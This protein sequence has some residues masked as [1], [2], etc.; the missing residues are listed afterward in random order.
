MIP[1]YTLLITIFL[2]SIITISHSDRAEGRIG[3]VNRVPEVRYES[4]EDEAEVDLKNKEALTFTWRPTPI[5]AGG[6]EG[7]RFKVFKGTGYDEIADETL[8]PRTFSIK[9]PAGKFKNEQT[10]SWQVQQ[11]SRWQPK[12]S[13]DVFWTFKV[14]K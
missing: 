4:P 7:Y 14:R 1:K 11:R 12:W 2:S 10:Y 3:T 5:P 13:R 8:G 6:R 9:I